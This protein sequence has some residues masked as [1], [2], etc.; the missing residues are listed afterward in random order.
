MYLASVDTD[1]DLQLSVALSNDA[2]RDV[3]VTVTAP[4]DPL[5]YRATIVVRVGEVSIGFVC[6]YLGRVVCSQC[7]DVSNT[8][9][10]HSKRCVVFVR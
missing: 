8:I 9:D 3:T 5:N 7:C 10:I 4:N 1:V 2:A 6:P